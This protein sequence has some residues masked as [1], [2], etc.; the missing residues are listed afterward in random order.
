[1]IPQEHLRLRQEAPR[2]A[3]RARAARGG[4]R[5]RALLGWTARPPPTPQVEIALAHPK[6]RAASPTPW[7]RR[8]RTS[9]TTST[10]A[11]LRSP[12]SAARRYQAPE[13][14]GGRRRHRHRPGRRG[15]RPHRRDRL[16]R[17]VARRS[18]DGH[19]RPRPMLAAGG[20]GSGEQIAA[21]L[22]MG[23]QGVW[24][25]SLW[26]T[27]EEADLPPA[28]KQQLLDATSA[29]HR[30][31]PVLHRQAL[32]HAAQRVDRRLGGPTTPGP[33]AACRCSTWSR[34]TAW[35]AATGTPT[36]PRPCSSTRSARSSASSTRCEK[37]SARHPAPRRGVPRGRRPPHE[38]QP[39]R[40]RLIEG[41]QARTRRNWS[42]TVNSSLIDS[43]T[44]LDGASM[45]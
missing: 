19:R 20:I 11:G 18:L 23:A 37:T 31:Q 26:L 21:A 1:M 35:P 17:A 16:D 3:R 25:G 28:Q 42:S 34:A 27:V 8:R 45:S 38:A 39:G 9:S 14:Q 32:P 22:A 6:V 2:R 29:G 7:A 4:E 41:R 5:A 33:A 43:T 44:G 40:R 13:A 24:T 12:R 15:R 30:A 36:R 10:R